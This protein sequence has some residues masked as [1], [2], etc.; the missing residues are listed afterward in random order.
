MLHALEPLKFFVIGSSV[1][2]SLSPAMH[3]AAFH[4]LGM[5][6]VYSIHETD[7]L[8]VMRTLFTDPNFGGASVSLPFKTRVLSLVE[9]QSAASK[10]IGGSN[11]ILPL[12]HLPDH[13]DPSDPRQKNQRHRAG[14]IAMLYADNTD[15]M[16]ICACVSRSI[17]PANSVNPETAALVIGAGGMAR[18]AIYCLVHLGVRNICIFNRTVSH[19]QALATHFEAMFVNFLDGKDKSPH[20]LGNSQESLRIKVLDSLSASWPEGFCQPN[21]VICAI[22]AYDQQNPTTP[23]FTMPLSWMKNPTGGIIV[24]VKFSARIISH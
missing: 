11:T 18:A 7:S 5:P 8:E 3:N 6:H 22:K 17:S 23:P 12:R 1:K 4:A 13:K 16:G 20:A 15:W 14:P 21:I 9:K 10:L 19:A 2:N 24:E